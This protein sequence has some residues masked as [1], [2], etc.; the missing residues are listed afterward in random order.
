MR[1]ISERESESVA[2]CA[3]ELRR[4]RGAMQ[5]TYTLC[6]AV[7]ASCWPRNATCDPRNPA[8]TILITR[9]RYGSNTIDDVAAGQKEL[10]KS[11]PTPNGEVLR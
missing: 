7:S 11:N 10:Y 3:A 1:V 2:C 4:S 8:L 9:V 6:T 5:V